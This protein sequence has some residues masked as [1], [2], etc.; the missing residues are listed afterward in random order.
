MLLQKKIDLSFYFEI[1]W[2]MVGQSKV[3]EFL[4]GCRQHLS[5]LKLFQ[6]EN[7]NFPFLPL[8]H[9]VQI[10]TL[11]RCP[12]HLLI[13]QVVTR[14]EVYCKSLPSISQPLKR[15]I[16]LY[17]LCWSIGRSVGWLVSSGQHSQFL[18]CFFHVS[19]F[20]RGGGAKAIWAMPI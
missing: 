15:Q 4:S 10:V 2:M 12:R 6:Q 19:P 13:Y 8:L 14:T 17:S 20:D 3:G 16:A 5:L 18:R 7:C 9:F 1:F 11:F